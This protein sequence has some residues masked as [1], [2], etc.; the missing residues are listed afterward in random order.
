MQDIFF[1]H[2]R[3]NMNWKNLK[4]TAKL[5]CGFGLV[6]LALAGL[7]VWATLGIGNIVDDATEVIDGNKL[8]G[9]MVQREV[10]HLTW[11]GALSALITDPEVTELTVQTDPHKCGFGQ[12][13]YGEGRKNAEHLVPGLKGLLDEIEQ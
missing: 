5:L 11:A 2:R 1:A 10:D 12:W 4:L 8:R 6:L 9:E 13:Y 3:R 7:G